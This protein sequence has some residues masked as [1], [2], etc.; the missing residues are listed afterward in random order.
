MKEL[1]IIFSGA[2]IPPIL[3][4]R[5]SATRRLDGLKRVNQEP[6]LWNYSASV[7]HVFYPKKPGKDK[8]P[9]ALKCPYEPPQRRWVRETCW[10]YKSSEIEMAG[11]PGGTITRKS[12]KT[13]YAFH[14]N[15]SF[16][17][18]ENDIWKKKPSIFMPRWASRITLEI[19]SVK[20]ERVQEIS[21]EDIEREGVLGDSYL[22]EMGITKRDPHSARIY[23][24]ELWDSLNLKRGYGWD[25]NNWVWAVSFKRL[26]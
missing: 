25:A 17:P 8:Y 22:Y 4:D 6:D 26:T 24:M 18:P 20:A 3:D 9:I 12:E 21:E 16:L 10:Y 13:G 19:L 2:M 15:D 11:F 5:K 23:F 7:G 14:R 1:P